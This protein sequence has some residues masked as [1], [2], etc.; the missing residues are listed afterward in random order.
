MLSQHVLII[1]QK[2]FALTMSVVVFRHL[3]DLLDGDG[4]IVMT[5][6]Y[7]AFLQMQQMPSHFLGT[8]LGFPSAPKSI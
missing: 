3:V 5:T 6:Y 7:R 4:E 2:P 8:P 1:R